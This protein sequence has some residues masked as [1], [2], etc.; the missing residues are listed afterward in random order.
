[1]RDS[2]LQVRLIIG[3]H[4]L[5]ALKYQII[6][7]DEMKR[8]ITIFLIGIMMLVMSGCGGETTSDEIE[9]ET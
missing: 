9:M 7:G 5:F 8:V 3:A 1:M 6:G 4:F 2:L